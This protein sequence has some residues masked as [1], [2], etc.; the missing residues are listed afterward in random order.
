MKA[1]ALNYSDY[2]E[3]LKA[4]GWYDLKHEGGQDNKVKLTCNSV[5][6]ERRFKDK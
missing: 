6:F 1:F 4:L 3:N 5:I 2:D